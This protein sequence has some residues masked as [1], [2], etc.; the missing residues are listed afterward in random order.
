MSL[1][2][3]SINDNFTTMEIKR[4]IDYLKK[5]KSL[6]I[7]CVPAEFKCSNL[8]TGDRRGIIVLSVIKNIFEIMYSFMVNANCALDEI[9]LHV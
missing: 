7:D 1:E 6:G 8:D 9:L 5:N 3:S 2:Y 4:A